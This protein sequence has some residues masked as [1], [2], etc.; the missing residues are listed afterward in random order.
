[1]NSE[2]ISFVIALYIRNIKKIGNT[3]VEGFNA[4]TGIRQ[5]S[6]LSPALFAI[7]ADILLRKLQQELANSTIRAFADDTAMVIT[8][9]RLLPP[10][11][12]TSFEEYAGFSNLGLNLKKR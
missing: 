12:I 1:M 10:Q 8:D 9:M 7:V 5:G 3:D 2:W 11:I 6:L 4:N